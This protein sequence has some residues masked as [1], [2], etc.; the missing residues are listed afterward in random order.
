MKDMKNASKI[1]VRKHEKNPFL[2]PRC[3]LEDNIKMRFEEVWWS[4]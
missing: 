2:I 1:L 3:N 4:V